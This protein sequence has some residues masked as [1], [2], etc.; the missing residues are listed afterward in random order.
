MLQ[1]V[2]D[3]EVSAEVTSSWLRAGSGESASS[4]ELVDRESGASLRL[5]PDNDVAQ[6]YAEA[7]SA[8]LNA[9]EAACSDEMATYARVSTG[10]GI[11]DLTLALLYDRG[12]VA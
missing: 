6:R 12:V 5:T 8:W 1:I 11:D 7:V 4:L 9:I 2:D 3:A 10:W